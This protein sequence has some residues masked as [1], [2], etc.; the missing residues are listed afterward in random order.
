MAIRI[1][2]A[3]LCV[4][5]VGQSLKKAI[6]YEELAPGQIENA[7]DS[8]GWWPRTEKASTVA[9]AYATLANRNGGWKQPVR[10]SYKTIHHVGY[11]RESEVKPSR[12]VSTAYSPISHDVRLKSA[13]RAW[14]QL[15]TTLA[16][17]NA[18]DWYKRPRPTGRHHPTPTSCSRP[19]HGVSPPPAYRYWPAPAVAI[20]VPNEVATLRPQL[21]Y[22]SHPEQS[23]PPA[24]RSPPPNAQSV[25]LL[26]ESSQRSSPAGSGHRSPVMSFPSTLIT[27]ITARDRPACLAQP[28]AATL[29]DPL[30]ALP[31]PWGAGNA[32]GHHPTAARRPCAAPSPFVPPPLPPPLSLLPPPLPSAS[33][34]HFHT[35]PATG[36]WQCVRSL[37]PPRRAAQCHRSRGAP[38]P[39]ASLHSSPPPSRRGGLQAAVTAGCS[40]GQWRRGRRP[41]AGTVGGWGGQRL[42]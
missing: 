19:A 38:P 30:P 16:S 25:W 6:F 17:N 1:A 29:Q 2:I 41:S 34:P 22:G 5:Y 21:V 18:N 42:R 12:A 32:S 40:D 3:I 14:H 33:R 37:P 11:L 9:P 13:I 4:K 31:P 7:F 27:V 28:A 35:P 15:S 24:P 23:T 26:P 10:S 36:G 8:T 20:P 39:T